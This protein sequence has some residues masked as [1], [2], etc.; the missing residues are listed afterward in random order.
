MIFFVPV[1]L[2]CLSAGCDSGPARTGPHTSADVRAAIDEQALQFPRQVIE[3]TGGVHVAVGYGL[4]NSVLIVGDGGV[5]IVDTMESAEAAAPVREEFRRISTAP[6]AAIVYTHN[7]ADH[8]FGAAVLAGEDH[9]QVIAHASFE[10]ELTRLGMMT[11]G[12]I[13]RRSMRQFGAMLPEADRT[14]CGIGP[15]LLNEAK[16]T[17]SPLLP[18]TTFDGDRTE[19]T[20]AGVHMELLHLP[21]ETPD[22]IAVWLPEK[23]VLVSGDNYYHSFPNLYA[24]RG[25]ATRD[26]L[27]WMDSIDR[28]R[29]LAP[30]FLVPGHTL[31]VTGEDEIRGRLT[32]YRDA[33]QYVHDQTVRAMNEGR[34]PDEIA[35]LVKLPKSLAS[36]PW[37]A[38]RYGRVDWSVRSIF[39][40]YLGWFGGDA[41]DLS[42]LT[43]REH[44]ERMAVLAG[45]S[46]KL[47]DEA[48]AAQKLGDSEWALELAGELAALGE[49]TE[50]A[51]K[52]RA[53]AL[54]SLASAEPNANGRNYELTQALE[55]EE[56]LALDPPDPSQMPAELLARIP[57]G[58][59][60]RAMT[61]RLDP[62]KAEGKS[63]A[64]GLRFPDTGE[65]WGMTVRNSV[66]E[67]SPKLPAEPDMTV[68]ADSLVWKEILTRK[69][70][71]T[72]AFASGDVKVD[73]NRLELV[74]FL[75][76]F[77]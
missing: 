66:V 64:I 76:L 72:A 34:E 17:L 4:A 18:T 53:S 55:A 27:D 30:A 31:P 63:M 48:V 47:R 39:D 70:N 12:V 51:K 57:V 19:M 14:N 50:V 10:T 71:A 68:T 67:L 26:V 13:W 62:V 40:K 33:I 56:Q 38:E 1:A 16:S 59:F 37:L 44:A 24:I 35:A 75:F 9:P 5:I 43:R 29:A 15:R 49:F 58:R 65:E 32:D 54:R 28:M 52:V 60:L 46:E 45:G 11:R 23:R 77:R 69:R 25:T 21:G 73:R 20:I 42:P 2:V 22:Q 74:R 8:I 41:A 7:H 3:V 36:R 61:V 6:V